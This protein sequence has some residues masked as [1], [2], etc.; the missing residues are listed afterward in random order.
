MS[1]DAWKRFGDEGYKHYSVVECGFKYNM[2]D[3]QAAVGIHQLKRVD[4]YWQKRRA[5]WGKYMAAFQELG[6]GLPA[7]VEAGTRHAY[8][9]FTVRINRQKTGISRDGFLNK[10]TQRKIGVGVHYLAIP[11]HPFYRRRFGWKPQDYPNAL[12]YGRETVSLPL[13]PKLTGQD[14]DD[15][16]SAVMDTVSEGSAGR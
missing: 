12:S 3:I 4:D 14:V 10:M 7:P 11:E 6:I 9:L 16:V 2:M 8:H 5:I 15:V 13:S 1:K